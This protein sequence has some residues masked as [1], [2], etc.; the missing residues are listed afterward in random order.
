VRPVVAADVERVQVVEQ[1]RV[2]LSSRTQVELEDVRRKP[3]ITGL[4]VREVLNVG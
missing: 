3:R 4:G 2:V 1:A